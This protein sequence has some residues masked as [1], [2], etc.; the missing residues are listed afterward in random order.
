M[1]PTVRVRVRVSLPSE[2]FIAAAAVRFISRATSLEHRHHHHLR[3]STN[4]ST[5]SLILDLRASG[6]FDPS[7]WAFTFSKASRIIFSD[8]D[9]APLM[10]EFIDFAPNVLLFVFILDRASPALT[11]DLEIDLTAVFSP[12]KELFV[13]TRTDRGE[14]A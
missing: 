7:F 9:G 13:V 4:R 11:R 5:K 8:E 12:P 10:A 1:Q 6:S 3:A 14:H 2:P